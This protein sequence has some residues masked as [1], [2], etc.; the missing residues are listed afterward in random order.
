MSDYT[1]QTVSHPFF[2]EIPVV[3]DDRGRIYYRSKNVAN[4]FGYKN[5]PPKAMGEH[6]MVT[7]QHKGL[8]NTTVEIDVRY[9]ESAVIADWL[10]GKANR[11]V[12]E[13]RRKYRNIINDILTFVPNK[14]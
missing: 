3:T 13:L 5:F 14:D 8:N 12:A 4:A 7:E 11:E 9:V 1:I 10:Q 2:R 6:K